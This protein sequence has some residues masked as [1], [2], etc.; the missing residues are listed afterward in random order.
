MHI[1]LKTYT[2]IHTNYIH[3]TYNETRF[4]QNRFE[5]VLT[6]FDIHFTIVYQDYYRENSTFSEVSNSLFC[7][8]VYGK[9]YTTIMCTYKVFGQK[10]LKESKPPL[11]ASFHHL[12]SSFVPIF[13]PYL[14]FAIWNSRLCGLLSFFQHTK[15]VA[16]TTWLMT[17]DDEKF[18]LVT[19]TKSIH[20]SVDISMEISITTCRAITRGAKKTSGIIREFH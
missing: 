13:S 4:C 16:S 12:P 2:Y 5:E 18:S 10:A 14:F 7:Y 9:I 1:I 8:L 19:R 20:A 15:A 17:K 3:N 6:V 11:W